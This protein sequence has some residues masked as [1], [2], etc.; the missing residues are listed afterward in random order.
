MQEQDI[1]FWS[2]VL[3][4]KWCLG[5]VNFVSEWHKFNWPWSKCIF[6]L[7]ADSN[8]D[9]SVECNRVIVSFQFLR[10]KDKKST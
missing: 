7:E 1:T 6:K 4:E 9:F 5:S 3:E 8:G 2:V 10:S